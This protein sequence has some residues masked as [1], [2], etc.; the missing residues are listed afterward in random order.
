MC[1]FV[2]ILKLVKH[3]RKHVQLNTYCVHCYPALLLL[4]LFNN[5]YALSLSLSPSRTHASTSSLKCSIITLFTEWLSVPFEIQMDGG[6]RYAMHW[7]LRVEE[8]CRWCELK[9]T[10]EQNAVTD[11]QRTQIHIQWHIPF[12]AAHCSLCDDQPARVDNWQHGYDDALSTTFAIKRN[13]AQTKTATAATL[14]FQIAFITSSLLLVVLGWSWCSRRHRRCC[15]CCWRDY[16]SVGDG[17]LLDSVRCW[18]RQLLI[19]VLSHVCQAR[20]PADGSVWPWCAQWPSYR[21]GRR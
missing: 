13:R 8:S 20:R 21:P 4:S 14:H 17:A 16:S 1:V 18:L 6:A 3:S 2:V 7:E 9:R 10:S 12:G 19:T 5:K 15:C 11:I